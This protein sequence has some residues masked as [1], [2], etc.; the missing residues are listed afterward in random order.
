MNNVVKIVSVVGFVGVFSLAVYGVIKATKTS[1]TADKLDY[2]IDAFTLKSVK[3]NTLG[4][5]TEN[6]N[7]SEIV[8]IL[9]NLR[10]GM[11]GALG[12]SLKI[13]TSLVYTISLKINNPTDQDL[14]ITKPYIRLSVKKANGTLA[15]IANTAIPEATELNIKAKTTTN[16]H[17]DIE[18]QIL[19][20][21]KVL[22]NFLEYIIGRL[23]GEKSTQQIIADATLDAMGLTIPIQKV[24]AL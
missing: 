5:V 7:Q 10:L 23:K 24:I 16:V 1:N 6:E 11:L 22:P 17:H 8:N 2:D 20:V 21:V 9:E 13:P 4:A 3:Q 18:F 12:L 15:K 14:V 19:N